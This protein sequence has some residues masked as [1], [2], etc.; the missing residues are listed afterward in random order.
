M[1]STSAGGTDYNTNSFACHFAK[2]LLY[3]QSELAET[4]LV[5]ICGT[6]TQDDFP[7]S[8]QH[9]NFS[10]LPQV[11]AFTIAIEE[12]PAGIE[13]QDCFN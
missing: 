12:A 3:S 13:S 6:R 11:F 1:I 8:L 4:S 2:P 5:L 10:F 7:A 9:P